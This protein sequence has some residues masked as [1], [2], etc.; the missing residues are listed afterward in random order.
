MPGTHKLPQNFYLALRR[1]RI[2]PV[3]VFF[4]DAAIRPVNHEF[5]TLVACNFSCPYNG[6]C[7]RAGSDS[8]P[9]IARTDYLPAAIR[10][11]CNMLIFAHMKSLLTRAADQE[12]HRRRKRPGQSEHISRS[13]YSKPELRRDTGQC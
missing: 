2:M 4:T 5:R 10:V 3:G 7:L 12:D 13:T 6:F 1:I 11:G 9:G 8:S